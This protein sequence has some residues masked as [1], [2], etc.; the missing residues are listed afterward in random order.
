MAGRMAK[1]SRQTPAL[2]AQTFSTSFGL[3]TTAGKRLKTSLSVGEGIY[4][5]LHAMNAGCARGQEPFSRR[6]KAYKQGSSQ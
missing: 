3:S 2:L 1:S 4:A 6:E 5:S